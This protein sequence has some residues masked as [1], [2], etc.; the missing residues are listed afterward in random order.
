[1]QL[2]NY[3]YGWRY[4]CCLWKKG[5]FMRKSPLQLSLTTNKTLTKGPSA[6]LTISSYPIMKLPAVISIGD[7][8]WF[9][10]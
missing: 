8:I 10:S 3:T 9:H 2:Q 6:H 1:M 4:F 7:N 5:L